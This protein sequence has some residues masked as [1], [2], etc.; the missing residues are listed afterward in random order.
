MDSPY[1]SSCPLG[2]VRCEIEAAVPSLLAELSNTSI[3]FV[4]YAT[5]ETRREP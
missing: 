4:S 5:V 3:S 1:A 2:A